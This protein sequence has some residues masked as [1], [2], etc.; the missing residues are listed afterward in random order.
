M[1]E[2]GRENLL[3]VYEFI[4]CPAWIA[5]KLQTRTVRAMDFPCERY[6]K[7]EKEIPELPEFQDES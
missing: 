1:P 2:F 3:R 6:C 4:K 5:M 7:Y